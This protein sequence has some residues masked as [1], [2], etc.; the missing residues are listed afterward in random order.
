MTLA[1]PKDFGRL[2][3]G[4]ASTEQSAPLL[5]PS[6]RR[7]GLLSVSLVMAGFTAMSVHVGLLAAGVPFP[8][9]RPPLWAQWLNESF[10][11]GG[12]LFFLM[13]AHPRIG[14]RNIMARIAI[15]FVIVAT[16]QETVRV[17]VM[18]GIV[19]GG[20]AYSAIGLIRPLIRVFILAVTCVVGVRWVR[21]VPSLLIA[22][23]VIA[24]IS[25][26]AR[27]FI[28]YALDPLIQHFA[29]LARP[30][31]YAFPYP[32]HITAAAYLTFAEAVAGSVMMTAL[33]WDSLPGSKLVRLLAVAL[34]V[35]LIKGVAG[36]TA[37]YSAFTGETVL[38]GAISWS[39]F[40]LEFLT[41]GALAGLAW[42][43]LGRERPAA[44]RKA[45]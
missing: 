20:W 34:L 7:P 11:A 21:N 39:Q 26:A 22:A 17:A 14:H 6:V 24:A 5:L 10:I 9:P 12:L 15:T 35:A 31:L 27:K 36:S 8:L 16:I 29:W 2:D 23:L 30:D 18:S 13:L 4:G 42:D 41:L 3:P 38:L 28:A 43:A 40:F 44:R 1:S 25:T 37:L 19:T 33:I 32:L 45:Q